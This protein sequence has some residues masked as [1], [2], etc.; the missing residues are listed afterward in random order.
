MSRPSLTFRRRWIVGIVPLLALLALPAPAQSAYACRC[1][2]TVRSIQLACLGLLTR[3][4][5]E[6]KPGRTR[7]GWPLLASPVLSCENKSHL[8]NPKIYF[9]VLQLFKASLK[10]NYVYACVIT[11]LLRPKQPKRTEKLLGIGEK[12][13]CM[14]VI[15]AA[16][17]KM[18]LR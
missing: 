4:Y 12:N 14:R 16:A 9:Q 8:G 10:G 15:R 1:F 17:R 5:R 3:S 7:R 11:D 2:P 6:S 18:K 13:A